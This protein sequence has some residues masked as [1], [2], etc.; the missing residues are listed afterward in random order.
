MST[1]DNHLHK[2]EKAESSAIKKQSGIENEE[3]ENEPGN[4]S[5]DQLE[6]EISK[7]SI[8]DSPDR[9]EIKVKFLI[10]VVVGVT[11]EMSTNAESHCQ[12]F[13]D[14]LKS[15]AFKKEDRFRY[16]DIAVVFGL[17]GKESDEEI[18]KTE[19]RKTVES[20]ITFKKWGFKWPEKYKIPYRLIREKNKRSE[21]TKELV[22][23][24]RENY[25][26]VQIYFCFFD[27]DTVDFN[28]VLSSYIDI[29]IEHNNP[30]VMST[31]FLFPKDSKFRIKSEHDRD[32]RIITAKHFPLGT[33]YPE[34]NFCVLLPDGHDTLP[35]R[36]TNTKSREMNMES[37]VLIRQVKRRQGFT[38]VFANKNTIITR[39]SR[40]KHS[41]SS[42]RTWAISA[43]T[44]GELKITNTCKEE[45]MK[46]RTNALGIYYFAISMLR[47]LLKSENEA[48]R[49]KNGRLFAGDGADKVI[50]AAKAVRGYLS[51]LQAEQNH[52]AKGSEETEEQ[53]EPQEQEEPEEKEDQEEPEELE[54]Q[55]EP[56]GQEEPEEQEDL[57]GQEEQEDPEDLEGQEEQEEP[58][59]QED[60][61]DLEGQE[62]QEDPED[63]EGQEGQEEPEDQEDPED[64]EG[65]EEQEEP[66]DLE[67]QEE[68]EEPEE[69]ED[70]EDLEGQEEQED[71]EDLEGQEEKS[72]K[73][74]KI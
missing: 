37:P 4:Y 71:P 65:Q 66:E 29:I 19:L 54:G 16:E 45:F 63:L 56:E 49:I 64:L 31:G 2:E 15:Q 3:E 53:K 52:D 1:S 47:N 7:L 59:E 67:G 57:E 55:K 20:E 9:K 39:D 58:E 6:T 21:H 28:E 10:N 23:N 8:K 74:Q 34:P 51:K 14:L 24:F 69:Q 70:P 22:R 68:Q 33:Y 62:E 32:V 43:Y 44:H 72:K 38:A 12:K 41:H 13:L 30:T 48:Q 46:S 25:P 17:N 35:E 61:E 36:F 40:Q 50:Q 73:T 42:P 26:E 27:A 11:R 60:P 5:L 18:V